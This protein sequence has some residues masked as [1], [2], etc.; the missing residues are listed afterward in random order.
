MRVYS[1]HHSSG[2][3]LSL[4]KGRLLPW[5]HPFNSL[6]PWRRRANPHLLCRGLQQG[7]LKYNRGDPNQRFSIR[8]PVDGAPSLRLPLRPCNVP[9]RI[10]RF[11]R[12]RLGV[13]GGA[14]CRRFPLVRVDFRFPPSRRTFEMPRFLQVGPA[15]GT[16]RA[17]RR[18]RGRGTSGLDF[19]HQVHPPIRGHAAK[20]ILPQLLVLPP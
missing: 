13:F 17:P 4:I 11:A 8:T 5:L 1:H 15:F 14:H 16:S 9:V 7:W 6:L 10:R 19:S 18:L 12:V 2:L 3:N 20:D